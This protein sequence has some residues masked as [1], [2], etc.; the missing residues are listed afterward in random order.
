[1]RRLE[2]ADVWKALSRRSVERAAEFSWDHSARQ[3]V[4]LA[5]EAARIS[6]R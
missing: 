5:E 4:D 1:V 2:Q 6:R 3:L